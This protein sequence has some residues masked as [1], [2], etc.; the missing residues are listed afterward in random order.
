MKTRWTQLLVL[1]FALALFA[2]A[3]S[4]AEKGVMHCFAFTE[5][6]DASEADWNAWFEATDELADKISGL[7]TVWYGKLKR[8]L[9]QFSREGA[10]AYLQWGVCMHFSDLTALEK[11][12][13]HPVHDAWGG[14]Y[15]KV[16]VPGSTTYDILAQ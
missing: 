4:A 16:R 12:A 11:Y 15:E 6:E 9:R 8:P 14:K 13:E 7:N 5:I 10:E 3:A 1:T 2:G